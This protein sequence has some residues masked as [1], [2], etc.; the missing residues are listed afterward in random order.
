MYINS[1]SHPV[2]LNSALESGGDNA[3]EI[4]KVGGGDKGM[5]EVRGTGKL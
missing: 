3:A 4:G 1:L 5:A 2:H